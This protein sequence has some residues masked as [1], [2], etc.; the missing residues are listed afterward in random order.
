MRVHSPRTRKIRLLPARLN[1]KPHYVFHPIRTVRRAMRGSYTARPRTGRS[2][3]VQMP[4]GLPLQVNPNEAIGYSI[5]NTSVFDP[6][7]TEVMYRLIDRGDVVVD[8]G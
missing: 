5:A 7:V 1:D 6:A 8:V 3:V 2:V 4:W